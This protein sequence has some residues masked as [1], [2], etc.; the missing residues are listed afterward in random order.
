MNSKSIVDPYR[1]KHVENL[2]DFVLVED[3]FIG[4]KMHKLLK[5]K[6]DKLDFIKIKLLLFKRYSSI[7][8]LEFNL[9]GSMVTLSTI[10]VTF[11]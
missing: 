6:H 4:D 11:V 10:F 8:A 7:S 1:R 5:R 2:H 9:R 3:F